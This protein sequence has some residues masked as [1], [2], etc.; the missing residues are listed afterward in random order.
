M[1]RKELEEVALRMRSEEAPKVKYSSHVLEKRNYLANLI[2]T[3]N[4][5]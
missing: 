4:Y 1:Q 3:R 2:K 5:R